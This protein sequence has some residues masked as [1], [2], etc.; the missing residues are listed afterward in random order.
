MLNVLPEC[1]FAAM[2]QSQNIPFLLSF[3]G[4]CGILN[5]VAPERIRFVC[6]RNGLFTREGRAERRSDFPYPVM[7]LFF[8]LV[9]TSSHQK[10]SVAFYEA[11]AR[12]V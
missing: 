11:V 10:A 5:L 2:L 1:S 3:S 6:E 8:L 12:V 9:D 4:N 7:N